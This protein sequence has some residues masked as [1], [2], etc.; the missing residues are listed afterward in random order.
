MFHSSVK[1]FIRVFIWIF[2]PLAVVSFSASPKPSFL[3]EFSSFFN[4]QSTRTN[5]VEQQTLKKQ[6]LELSKT[7]D[8]T[9]LEIENCIAELRE[10]QDFQSTASSTLLKKKW[11]LVWTTEKEINFFTDFSGDI[12]QTITSDSLISYIPFEK[13]G[14]FEVQGSILADETKEE[15]TNFKFQSATLDLGWFKFNIPPIGEGWFDT[16]Y[17]D[18]DLRVDINSRDDILIVVPYV[19]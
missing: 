13:G 14:G 8:V 7:K 19:N 3:Q 1:Q 17:L 4:N 9:R 12:T 2:S 18:E 10:V 6:L 11:L 15:R 5:R 16:V